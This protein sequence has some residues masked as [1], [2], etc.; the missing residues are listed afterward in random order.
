[1]IYSLIKERTAPQCN[2]QF[3][4]LLPLRSKWEVEIC[5]QQLSTSVTISKHLFQ[6]RSVTEHLNILVPPPRCVRWTRTLSGKPVAW[7]QTG[8]HQI[9]ALFKSFVQ[10]K[11]PFSIFKLKRKLSEK[12]FL[13]KET[14]MN[15]FIPLPEAKTIMKFQWNILSFK[16]NRIQNIPVPISL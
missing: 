12:N 15:T 6:S 13:V 8:S 10:S 4:I 7:L 1:M 11:V 16:N 3:K 2:L 9:T 14:L 5:D